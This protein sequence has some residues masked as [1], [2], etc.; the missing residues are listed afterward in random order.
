MKI[1]LLFS[2]L[3]LIAA[4]TASG[5]VVA[6]D[7]ED[8]GN[9]NLVVT[10]YFSGLWEQTRHESQ[11]IVLQII[12]QED[13]DGD[14]R[15]VAYWFTYGDD[16]QT[17]WYM[18]IGEVEGDQVVMDLYAANGV[19]FLEPESDLNPVEIEGTLTLTFKNCNKGMA[20]YTMS[21][22]EGEFEINRLAGLYNGRC[23][24]GISDNTPGDAKPLMLEVALLPP[25]EDGEG[26][27]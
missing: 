6:D 21:E 18:A 7:D 24:G 26:K 4:A 9:E 22:D 10:R 3:F 20:A 1:R 25:G 19:G 8:Y 14:P 17:A 2:L 13:D 12:D 16:M 5:P 27:G 23:S 15:A 11:G